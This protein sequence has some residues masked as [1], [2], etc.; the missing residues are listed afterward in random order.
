M[1][2]ATG[3]LIAPFLKARSIVPPEFRE[4]TQ[5]LHEFSQDTG[6]STRMQIVAGERRAFFLPLFIIRVF[7]NDRL[8]I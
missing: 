8:S 1:R 4:K 3:S 6:L 5:R 7:L 2:L